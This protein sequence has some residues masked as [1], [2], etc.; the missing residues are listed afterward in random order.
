MIPQ[1]F[2]HC[3]G[4]KPIETRMTNGGLYV[5]FDGT[6]Y[7]LDLQKRRI[8]EFR[9]SAAAEIKG[10]WM[11]G[12]PRWACRALQAAPLGYWTRE[13]VGKKDAVS[14]FQPTEIVES[15][16]AEPEADN[17]HEAPDVSTH[18]IDD[19][20]DVESAASPVTEDDLNQMQVFCISVGGRLIALVCI[21]HDKLQ[22]ALVFNRD[23]NGNW[24]RKEGSSGQ[25]CTPD[26][27]RG[28]GWKEST[29][30]DERFAPITVWVQLSISK[31]QSDAQQAA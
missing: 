31:V 7:R 19:H 17:Y 27:L 5:K 24:S 15:S 8:I 6:V 14:Y 26:Q 23:N 30:G 2:A 16:F 22:T 28:K 25:K 1:G 3:H 21:E 18:Q 13:E 20:S 11:S 12:A 4:L 10:Q 9:P 29:F